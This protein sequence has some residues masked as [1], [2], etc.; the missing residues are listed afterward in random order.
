MNSFLSDS[1]L[2]MKKKHLGNEI[3][4]NYQAIE[5]FEEVLDKLQNYQCR[6]KGLIEIAS[7]VLQKFY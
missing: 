2:E 5:H 7:R 3:E 6:M 1:Q 4:L